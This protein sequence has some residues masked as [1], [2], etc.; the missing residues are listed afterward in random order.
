[1][2]VLMLTLLVFFVRNSNEDETV[3][4]G[5]V[6]RLTQKG[7]T[8]AMNTVLESVKKLNLTAFSIPTANVTTSNV[9]YSIQK[10]IY[11]DYANLNASI[12]I[13]ENPGLNVTVHSL[14]VNASGEVE[15]QAKDKRNVQRCGIEMTIS[16]SGNFLVVI[17][18]NRQG[19]FNVSMKQEKGS[20][21]ISTP[22]LKI[23][24]TNCDKLAESLCETNLLELE[25]KFKKERL[26]QAKLCFLARFYFFARGDAEMNTIILTP[27]IG[28][29]PFIANLLMQQQPK[30][31]SS[32][33]N[34]YHK[35]DVLWF[36]SMDKISNTENVSYTLHNESSKMVYIWISKEAVRSLFKGAQ[37]HGILKFKITPEKLSPDNPGLNTTCTEKVCVGRLVPEL[38]EKYPNQY[39]DLDIYSLE[40]PNVTFEKNLAVIKLYTVMFVYIRHPEKQNSTLI[41]KLDGNA[42]MRIRVFMTNSTF[43][44]N[45][46]AFEPYLKNM[47]STVHGFDMQTVN[48][49]LMSAVVTTVE[50]VLNELGRKGMPLPLTPKIQLENSTV[51]LIE[52]AIVIGSDGTYNRTE[53]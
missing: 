39:M 1:M 26:T 20:C 43:Q 48:F 24:V 49:I 47:E 3:N 42:E 16:G 32:F 21:I 34:T 40:T 30:Y 12:L 28:Q 33:L 4:V 11:T 37:T 29:T 13:N 8:Y 7:L 19:R 22:D 53:D 41:A 38:E 44:G 27:R 50:P 36:P 46:V 25:E 9:S 2:G 14:S 6:I 52:N 10:L 5:V 31:E 17:G 51:N 18:T 23:W 15:C 35:G 45:I